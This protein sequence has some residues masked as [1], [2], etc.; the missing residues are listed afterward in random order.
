MNSSLHISSRQNPHFKRWRSL[1]DA[2]GVKRHRQCLAAGN[3]LRKTIETV[4]GVSV[5]ELLLPPSWKYAEELSS[6]QPKPYVLSHAL[7]Q[8]LD[9]FGIKEPLWVCGTPEIPSVDLT[10][11]PA[12]LEVLC[13]MGDPGNLGTFIRC[14][15]AFDVRTVILLREA[16]HPF[17]PKTIRASSGAVFIQP[18]QWGGSISEL[19]TIETLKWITALDLEGKNLSTIEWSQHLRLL[20]G[21]EGRGVPPFRFAERLSIPQVNSSI[22]LNATMAGGIALFAYRR[23]F[24]TPG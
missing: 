7:F 17:H 15:R 14:C 12:G 21:E 20:I 8:E 6:C 18:L 16:A 5:Q 10:Q 4:S 19:N 24:S 23:Y 1:L 13:P 3:T 22:P 9:V 2:Q 11:A